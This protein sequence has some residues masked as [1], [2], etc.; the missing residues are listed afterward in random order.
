MGV[1]ILLKKLLYIKNTFLCYSS[2]EV[3]LIASIPRTAT[4]QATS[5][6]VLYRLTRDDFMLILTEFS[7]MKKRVETI[8]QER[9]EKVRQEEITRAKAKAE[10]E[11]LELKEKEGKSSK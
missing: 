10:K 9:M 11:A 6:C 7:D 4:I 3:A 2:V 5:S 1:R 8:Y